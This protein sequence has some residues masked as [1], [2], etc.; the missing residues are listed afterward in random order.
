MTTMRFTRLISLTLCLSFVSSL[1][2]QSV[3]KTKADTHDSQ[4]EFGIRIVASGKTTGIVATAP[5]P[6]EWP[7]QQLQ[8]IAI[9]K[10]ENVERATFKILDKAVKQM[11]I[12]VKQL[13]EGETAKYPPISSGDHLLSK[14]V[15][16][17]TFGGTQEV[18]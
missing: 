1:S 12:R 2:A 11:T 4:W 16:Q 15:K 13:K 6:I 18:A 3:P 17:T 8:Q 14:F 5:I 10:S 9:A 7:E